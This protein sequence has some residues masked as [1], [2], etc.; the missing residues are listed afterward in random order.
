MINTRAL[1][2]W[3]WISLTP[4]ASNTI[5]SCWK[6]FWC[7]LC[8]F[9]HRLL[10]FLLGANILS[11]WKALCVMGILLIYLFT[12]K[13]ACFQACP[14]VSSSGCRMLS[15]DVQRASLCGIGL[16]NSKTGNRGAVVRNLL[17]ILTSLPL[18][19]DGAGDKIQLLSKHQSSTHGMPSSI[20][21]V[22]CEEDFYQILH[23]MFESWSK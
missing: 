15:P 23:N 11:K 9:F 19:M 8:I 12:R 4:H 20:P 22:A 16:A 3:W 17:C 13:A 10:Q 2:G 6:T 18:L 14:G 1:I 7:F 21:C 5:T